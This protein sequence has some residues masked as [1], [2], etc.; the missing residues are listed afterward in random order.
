MVPS[1]LIRAAVISMFACLL[2]P[3]AVAGPAEDAEAAFS[4]FF[5]AFVARNQ[6]QVA[7]MFAPDG[8]FYGTLSPQLVLTPE[9]VHRYFSVALDRPDTVVATPVQL[10]AKALSDDVVL[11]AGLW[12]VS[13][14]LDGKTMSGGPYRM[15]AVMQKRNGNW[16]VVQFHNSPLP[17][18]PAA[19]PAASR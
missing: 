13:R 18:A 19:Q 16:V 14:T 5:P 12:K 6:D 7:A 8:Q 17:A 3:L 4:K 11:L 10:N 1:S 2:A 15:S 9:G